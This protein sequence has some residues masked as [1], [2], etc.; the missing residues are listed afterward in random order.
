VED[1][2]S[3]FEI[4]NNFSTA[5]LTFNIIRDVPDIDISEI[6]DRI[7]VATANTLNAAILTRDDEIEELEYV[8]TVWS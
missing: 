5:S 7:I 2:F 8:N 6:H 1:L 4:G 3:K